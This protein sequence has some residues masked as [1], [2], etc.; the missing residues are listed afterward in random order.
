M[1]LVHLAKGN[2]SGEKDLKPNTEKIHSQTLRF[3]AYQQEQFRN[4]NED[5]SAATTVASI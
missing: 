3:N 4:N 1:L 2:F 5:R